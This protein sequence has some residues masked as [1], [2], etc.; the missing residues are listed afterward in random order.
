ME[1][2]SLTEQILKAVFWVIKNNKKQNSKQT[3]HHIKILTY[4]YIHYLIMHLKRTG[5]VAKIT[6]YITK[7]QDKSN[8][9]A[10][11]MIAI[12]TIRTSYWIERI[13]KIK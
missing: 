10:N 6:V 8:E 11:K 7:I 5:K 4:K 1:R 2:C 9:K 13:Q 3:P 12:V